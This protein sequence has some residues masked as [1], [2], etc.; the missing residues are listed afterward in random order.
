MNRIRSAK[1]YPTKK[2]ESLDWTSVFENPAP[3][4]IETL[5]TGIII[6]RI[7]ELINLTNPKAAQLS[8]GSARIPV[9]AHI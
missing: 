5:K 2:S 4:K 8:D 6:S 3:I 9:L 1:T 7:S